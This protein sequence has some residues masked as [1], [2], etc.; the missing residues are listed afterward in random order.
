MPK[1]KVLLTGP[2]GSS[3]STVAE[4][5]ADYL[6]DKPKFGNPKVVARDTS[7]LLDISRNRKTMAGL[8][9]SQVTSDQR[10]GK[11]LDAGPV[12][13]SLEENFSWLANLDGLEVLLLAGSPRTVDEALY[14]KSNPHIRF[15]LIEATDA[16]VA[17]SVQWRIDSGKMRPDDG[18]HTLETKL[19]EYKEKIIP[20][21]NTIPANRMLR[22]DRTMSLTS[23]VEAVVNHMYVPGSQ[24]TVIP[25]KIYERWM[26]RLRTRN[27]PIHAAIHAIENPPITAA[28]VHTHHHAASGLFPQATVTA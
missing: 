27:H 22:I 18:P 16:Q 8:Q 17:A 6:A 5:I 1:S 2:S 23:R 12:I 25:K 20:A 13:A 21:A 4:L 19:K 3:K 24:H 26:D 10:A 28:R 9:L 7:A 15:V 11:V 14:L